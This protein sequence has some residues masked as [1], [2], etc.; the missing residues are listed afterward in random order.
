MM[1]IPAIDLI[2]GKCVR[3]SQG[4]YDQKTLYNDDPASVARSF[5]EQGAEYLHIVDLDAA[6]NP[7]SNNRHTIKRVLEAIDVPVEVGGGVRGRS[8]VEQLLGMGVDR[9]ILG[10]VIVKDEAMTRSLVSEYGRGVVAGIDARNGLVRISGWTEG[11]GMTA[12]ELGERVRDMG[13]SRIIYTD[14]SR[15]GMLEGPNVDAITAMTSHVGMPLIAAGG[16]STMDDLRLIRSTNNSLIE[17]VISGKAIYEGK[18][19]V[20]EACRILGDSQIRE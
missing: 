3:L 4:D 5:Q 18:L 13:F 6:K 2:D 8:D 19:S 7:D 20:D 1:F 10:T 9:C 11:S 16:I 17:G 14:I 15:D 12:L